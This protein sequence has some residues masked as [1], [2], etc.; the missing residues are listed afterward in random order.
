MKT[1]EQIMNKKKVYKKEMDKVLSKEESGRLWNMATQRMETIIKDNAPVP[2]GVTMHAE[3]IFAAAAI[4]LTLK[5]EIGDEKAYRIIED[6]AIDIC[7]D[8]PGKLNKLLALPGMKSLFV[9]M[10][11]PMTRKIFGEGN[12]F[13]NVFYPN[14][15]GEYRMDIVSCPYFRYFTGLGCPEITRIFCENDERIYGKLNGLIFKRKGTLGKGADRCD[16]YIRR[17]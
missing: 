14:K 12:G 16:F 1:A 13:K 8:I 4:Y 7:K 10:W 3:K 6:T 11:D 2:E 17:S 9:K 5:D 15:K